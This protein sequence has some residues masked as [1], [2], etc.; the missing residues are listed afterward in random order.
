MTVS[1]AYQELADE[2]LIEKR[3]GLGVYV[4]G[5]VREAL[6]RSERERLLRED[7]M[8]IRDGRIVL[9]ASMDEVGERFVEV[10]VGPD[11]ADAARAQAPR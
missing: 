4:T 7:L 8:F 3:R 2:Q 10:I 11:K 9:D 5:G 6:L 1:K